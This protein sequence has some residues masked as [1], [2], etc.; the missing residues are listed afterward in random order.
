MGDRQT[1]VYTLIKA[2]FF[3]RVYK[4]VLDFTASPGSAVSGA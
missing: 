1:E 4:R 3:G 2:F